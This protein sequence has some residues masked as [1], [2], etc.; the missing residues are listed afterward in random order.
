MNIAQ[1]MQAIE[2]LDATDALPCKL[3]LSDWQQIASY[4][5]MRFLQPGDVL[6]KTGDTERILFILSEGELQVQLGG[7]AIA[8]LL[9]GTVV[10]EGPFFPATAAAPTW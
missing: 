7:H 9:P 3:P 6:I 10:G 1:L 4:L 5:N 8:T 2:T